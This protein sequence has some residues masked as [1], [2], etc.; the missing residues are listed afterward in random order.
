MTSSLASIANWLD[1]EPAL[2]AAQWMEKKRKTHLW[3]KQIEICN[4][5]ER[6]RYTTVQS[7]DGIGKSFIAANLAAWWIGEHPIGE[8]FV[9]TSAPTQTQVEAIL[10][11]EISKTHEMAGLP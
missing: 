5:V 11:Q 6:N 8:A 4:S 7:C 10:W 2:T 9:V 1:P 3:S